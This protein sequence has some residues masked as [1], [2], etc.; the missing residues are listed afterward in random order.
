[1]LLFFIL[2]VSTPLYVCDLC[3]LILYT[4]LAARPY[5]P[6]ATQTNEIALQVIMHYCLYTHTA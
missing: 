3:M 2:L 5:G 4:A 1:M 6:P